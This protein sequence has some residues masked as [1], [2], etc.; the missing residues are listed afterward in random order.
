MNPNASIFDPSYIDYYHP[1]YGYMG[2]YEEQNIDLMNQGGYFHVNTFSE[3]NQPLD[4]VSALCFDKS[5][6]ILWTGTSTVSYFI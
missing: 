3:P 1:E 5:E 6:E 4:L 2:P